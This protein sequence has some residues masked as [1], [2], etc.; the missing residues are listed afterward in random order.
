MQ[1]KFFKKKTIKK[2][3]DK[4]TEIFLNITTK[5]IFFEKYNAK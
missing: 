5:L 3:W 1:N 2:Y 4:L